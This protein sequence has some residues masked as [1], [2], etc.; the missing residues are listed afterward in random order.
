MAPSDP[1]GDAPCPHCGV[2]LWFVVR[3]SDVYFF[4]RQRFRI[5]PAVT[6]DGDEPTEVG[7][8]VRISYGT[9]ENFE[10]EVT[11]VDDDTNRLTITIKIF[12]R[13]TPIELE[14]WQV[15]PV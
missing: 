1:A 9:F 5:A 10:G 6:H 7:S 2:L 8:R 11:L 12:G 14:A 13:Q 15:E 3:D 4:D